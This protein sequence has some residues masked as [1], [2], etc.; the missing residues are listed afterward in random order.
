MVMQTKCESVRCPSTV[1]MRLFIVNQIQIHHKDNG[2]FKELLHCQF[3]LRLS[4]NNTN[5]VW[6]I[7]IQFVKNVV[8]L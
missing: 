4:L 6:S 7:L 2:Y 8:R 3:W 5:M 1:N